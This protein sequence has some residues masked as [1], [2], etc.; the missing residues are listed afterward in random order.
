[1]MPSKPD[2]V[3]RQAGELDIHYRDIWRNFSSRKAR[4]RLQQGAASEL[5]PIQLQSLALLAEEALRIG[6]LAD[7]LGLA[8]SSVTRLVDRLE[9]MGLA[10]R[11]FSDT[12]RRVVTVKL[13]S[14]GKRIE[15]AA[16]RRRLDYFIDILSSL[17]PNDRDELVRL[18]AKIASVQAAES[19]PA[20]N[21]HRRVS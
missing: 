15:A 18:F 7:K 8:T 17:A 6:T 12:D 10:K 4:T 9:R 14:M 2:P 3:A 5:S 21:K 11:S 19:E 20:D 13:T 16:A 1:M